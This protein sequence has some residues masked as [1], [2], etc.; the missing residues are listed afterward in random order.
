[1]EHSDSSHC[2]NIKYGKI[3]RKMFRDFDGTCIV[4]H[5][6]CHWQYTAAK[7]L[8]PMTDKQ[9]LLKGSRVLWKKEKKGQSK[10]KIWLQHLLNE[11]SSLLTNISRV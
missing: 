9:G 1:M 4:Y 10:R 3:T 2:D 11:P 8:G 6:R 7:R 5:S